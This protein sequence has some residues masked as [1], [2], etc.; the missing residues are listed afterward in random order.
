M[1]YV[2]DPEHVGSSGGFT[3]G[4]AMGWF[5]FLSSMFW[6]RLGILAWWIFSNL[7][8]RAYDSAIVPIVGFFVLPW[9]TVTYAMMWGFSSDRV[10]GVE[11]VVVAF[12]FL[13]DILTYA[14][15]GPA[16]LTSATTGRREHPPAYLPASS[17][18][19][20]STAL[21]QSATSSSGSSSRIVR[22]PSTRPWSSPRVSAAAAS[23]A[24]PASARPASASSLRA[25][26]NRAR[27]SRPP[28]TWA[29]WSRSSSTRS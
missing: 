13:L 9:T 16:P 5:L 23:P 1:S 26:A 7:L 15:T 20:A 8:G 12:A 24:A 22:K 27:R 17:S 28:T 6:P 11:W 18:S 3:L 14:G 21:A 4:R 19:S 2:G 10:S 29:S 25:R